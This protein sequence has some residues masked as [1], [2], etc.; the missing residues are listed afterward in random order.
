MS[1]NLPPFPEYL[2][3]LN[4]SAEVEI[5]FSKPLKLYLRSTELVFKQVCFIL[6][7]IKRVLHCLGS[8]L[9]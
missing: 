9:F 3:E 5:D 8:Y 7:A 2:K 4:S 1:S 6:I